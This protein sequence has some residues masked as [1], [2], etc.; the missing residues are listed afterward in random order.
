MGY[1]VDSLI[2][3]FKGE[4]GY[5]EKYK[6]ATNLDSK[7]AQ[8]GS[9][10]QT[11]YWIDTAPSL[12]GS[13]WCAD[14]ITWCFQ[15]QF[16]KEATTK[17]LLHYPYI[18]C[19]K[20]YDLGKSKGQIYTNPQKGDI[21]LFYNKTKKRFSHTEF[22]YATD[23][24][25]FC[26]VGGN[27]SSNQGNANSANVVR[28]GGGVHDKAYVTKTLVSNGSV[29]FRPNYGTQTTQTVTE[30]I[31]AVAK[32]GLD[33]S[34]NQGNIDQAK[35]AKA[36]Y[37]YAILRCVK[38]K[39]NDEMFETNYKNAKE[40]GIKVGAYIYSYALS[41]N[42]AMNDAKRVYEVL[43]G[44]D[45]DIPLFLDLEQDQQGKL[46][47]TAVTD[48]AVAFIKEFQSLY[49]CP[50]GIYS[51]QNWHDTL[52]DQSRLKNVPWQ[53]AR[54]SASDTG[55]LK[56]KPK[57]NDYVIHQY[58]WK[59]SVPGIR[60]SV[61]LDYIYGDIENKTMTIE[62]EGTWEK[63]GDKYRYKVN[64]T[65]IKG[66]Q[67]QYKGFQYLLSKDGQMLTGQ[68]KVG[69]KW[70]YLEN[71]VGYMYQNM[72]FG[73][74][75]RQYYLSSDGSMLSNIQKEYKGRWYYLG[76]DGAS[77]SSQ[78]FEYK[79]E[80]YYFD[81]DGVMVTDAYV[82]DRRGYCYLNSK[83]MQDGQY[84]DIIPSGKKVTE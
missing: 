3:V 78:W 49:G 8:A 67:A 61:D 62:K 39:D 69:G 79:K 45:L 31:P 18:S 70:Y 36:G 57:T 10:N 74:A 25:Y 26:C 24:T 15:R 4:V 1:D 47:K 41:V 82:K 19:Q 80:W 6:G 68:Q 30:T 72:W 11:K 23:S 76:A 7:T 65:Y 29:F 56:L 44:K 83:G 42:D 58:S 81:K 64:G 40:N 59:G 73:S 84:L 63:V 33:V 60:G 51:N 43:K 32:K 46:G 27:T 66:Q 20:L 2:K 37:E 75:G 17:L 38:R 9:D 53:A 50:V 14:F 54:V 5:L 12:Q 16:G 48:I 55:V 52:I 28:N 13:Y 77:K 71:T 34:S 21:A 35:V 22:V